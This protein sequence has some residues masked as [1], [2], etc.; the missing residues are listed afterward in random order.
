[1]QEAQKLGIS[2]VDSHDIFIGNGVSELIIMTAQGLIDEGDEVLVPAP[3]YPLWSA[4]LNLAGAKVVY[5]HCDEANNWYPDINDIRRKVTR[6]TKAILVINPNNPTGAVYSDG[7]LSEISDVARDHGLMIFAD[8]IY[9]KLLFD[10]AKHTSIASLQSDVLCITYNGLSKAYR[11][12]GF[13]CGWATISGPKALKKEAREAFELLSNMR[14]CANTTAQ[15]AVQTA[16]GGTQS[17]KELVAADSRLTK[18]RNLAVDVLSSIPGVNVVKP[19]GGLYIFF[20]LCA[21]MYPI[22]SDTRF[23]LDFLLEE[24]VLIVQGSGFHFS[25]NQHFRM[26]FLAH[27][28]ELKEAIRRLQSF[29]QRYHL[30][31]LNKV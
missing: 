30:S 10:D 13:R 15:L 16:L 14:L 26:V 12:A 18:Q 2:D 24:K 20:S 31:A 4:A 5:Y 27:S 25:G 11:G 22:E 21:K 9:D 6:C 28:E 17:I 7:L 29:L 8:E 1:M 19:Q 23:V 3:D